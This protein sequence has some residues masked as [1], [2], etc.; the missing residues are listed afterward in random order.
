MTVETNTHRVQVEI[1]L[2]TLQRLLAEQQLAGEELRCLNKDS[3]HSLQR[4]FLN[5]LKLFSKY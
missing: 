4:L 5:N 2:T 1:S 3:K